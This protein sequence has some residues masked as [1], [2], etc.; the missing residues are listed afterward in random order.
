[1]NTEHLDVVA[2]VG[3]HRQFLADDL[4][5]PGCELGAA[6]ASGEQR[7]LHAQWLA[8]GRPVMRIPAWDL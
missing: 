5:H 6:A 7:D 3:D 4:L 8:S 2:G 1:M